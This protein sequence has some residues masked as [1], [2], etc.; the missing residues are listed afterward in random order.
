M[1]VHIGEDY[2]EKAIDQ[3]QDKRLT[4]KLLESQPTYKS[5][6]RTALNTD[7]NM[8][9]SERR[10]RKIDRTG[11]SYVRNQTRWTTELSVDADGT[12]YVDADNNFK[13]E[14]T[15]DDL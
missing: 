12:A 2:I 5:D 15:H 7:G 6:I 3:M 9:L 14:V 1:T 11:D 13:Y 8:R 10:R 4:G